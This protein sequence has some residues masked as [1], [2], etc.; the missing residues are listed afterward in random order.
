MARWEYTIT[1]GKALHEAIADGDIELVVKCL[2]KCYQELQSKL[3][4]DDDAWKGYEIEDAIDILTVYHISHD[5]D[6]EDDIDNYLDDFYNLCD[7]LRA[8]ITL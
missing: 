8:W 5:D 3:S 6:D 1:N 2:L 7:E 4:E